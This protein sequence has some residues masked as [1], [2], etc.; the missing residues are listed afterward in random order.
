MILPGNWIL[1]FLS[2]SLSVC[3]TASL[4]LL[5][6]VFCM[7]I[8]RSF[9]TEKTV[10]QEIIKKRKLVRNLSSRFL[11]TSN[12]RVWV[13]VVDEKEQDLDNFCSVDRE[14]HKEMREKGETVVTSWSSSRLPLRLPRHYD[15]DT[16]HQ[17]KR[18]EQTPHFTQLIHSVSNRQTEFAFPFTWWSCSRPGIVA[19]RRQA[20]Q[21]TCFL[22]PH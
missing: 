15:Q 12:D 7:E 20:C 3:L 9:L 18:K 19:S 8:R 21:P 13:L 5:F 16:R 11:S 10:K 4:L 6:P 22:M 17:K 14:T 1:V 2:F